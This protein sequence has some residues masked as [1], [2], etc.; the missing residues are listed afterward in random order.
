MT[1][2]QGDS[3]SACENYMLSA[4]NYARSALGEGALNLPSNWESLST[5]EQLFVMVDMERVAQGYPAYLGL[6]AALSAEAASAAALGKDANPAVP[7]FSI[8]ENPN[9][10]QGEGGAWA[11]AFSVLSADY[12]WMYDDGWAGSLATTPNID[13]TSATAVGCW[14]HRDSLL[15]EQT[16]SVGVGLGCD[17]CELGAGV[18][19][20]NGS[21]SYTVMIEVPS[22]AAPAMTFTWAQELPYFSSGVSTSIG[23]PSTNVTPTTIPVSLIGPAQ[24]IS[25]AVGRL[26]LNMA[27]VSWES[28]N[29]A[30]ITKVTL[31]TFKGT[32][33][34]SAWRR[35]SVS[36][37]SANNSHFG[38]VAS[39]GTK[40]YSPAGTFSALVKIT[41]TGNVLSSACITLGRS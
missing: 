5:T 41:Y 21:E 32:G 40:F 9:G 13:C 14:G 1:W 10:M 37:N 26:S 16:A 22:G 23:P 18:A 8:G 28:V 6:N 38:Y 7:G 11:S 27:Q 31:Y 25:S 15:G 24:V 19:V 30:G 2:I 4:I 12:A 34:S 39:S 17:T 29:A 3:N 35:A 36:F 20:L 33:C